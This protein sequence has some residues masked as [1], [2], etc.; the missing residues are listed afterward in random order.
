M[1]IKTGHI[2]SIAFAFT[3]AAGFA[4]VLGG[5]VIFSKRFVHLANPA[6]LAIAL[7]I[8]VGV[9]FFISFVEI[10]GE[11]VQL[12]T[13][14]IQKKYPTLS[15][16]T[17][18]GH[19]WLLATT[20]FVGVIIVIYI[21]DA[22]VHKISPDVHV[23]EESLENLAVKEQ[24]NIMEGHMMLAETKGAEYKIAEATKEIAVESTN[25]EQLENEGEVVYVYHSFMLLGVKI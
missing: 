15:H 17:A 7:A 16:K 1:T 14:G 4:T 21:V 13:E 22:I 23:G 11:S 24:L 9:M 8:S 3:F 18:H 25:N 2:V 19:G 20:C 5:C 12:F 6:S 10:F